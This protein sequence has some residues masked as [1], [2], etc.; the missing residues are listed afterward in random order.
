MQL[1]VFD[2]K[3]MLI[4]FYLNFRGCRAIK[5]LVENSKT[6]LQCQDRGENNSITKNDDGSSKF[7]LKFGG[8]HSKITF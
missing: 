1:I 2:Q 4:F 3:I 6:Q 8:V 5:S 7:C